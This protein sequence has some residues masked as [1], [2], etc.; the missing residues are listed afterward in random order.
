MNSTDHP[1]ISLLRPFGG[2]DGLTHTSPSSVLA[3]GIGLFFILALLFQ[4]NGN[5]IKCFDMDG[6]PM[7]ELCISGASKAA[8]LFQPY[9][10]SLVAGGLGLADNGD[11]SGRP[12]VSKQGEKLAHDEPYIICSGKHREVVLHAAEHV[13]EFFRNDSKDH[14]KPTGMN[15]GDYFNR[16]SHRTTN[17]C[18]MESVLGQCVGA[19]N[20][21]QWR[22]VRSYFDPAYTGNASLAMVPS[23]QNEVVKWL[24]MLKNDSLRTGVRRLVVHA[25]TSCKILLL[26]VIPQTFYGAAYDDDVGM[27]PHAVRIW[28]LTVCQAYEKLVRIS[29]IQGQ[30]LKYVMAGGWQQHQWFNM[31]PTPSR[32][33]LDLYHRDW[34]AFNLEMLETAQK[35]GLAIP[36]EH[37]FKGVQ[38]DDAMSMDQYL[39]TIDEMIFINIDITGSVLAFM[40][41]N[42][43]KHPDFQQKLYEEIVAQKAEEGFDLSSYLARQTTLLHYLCLESVRLRPATWFSVPECTTIDKVIG[44]Y[45]IPARTP[46]I[47]DVRRLN[48]NA[49]TWGLDGG[50]FRPERFAGR[51]PNEY[52]YGYMRFGVVSGK[53][54]GKHMADVLMKV[55]M[56]T[57]LEQYKIEEIEM[58]IGV[59]DG[60]L[61]FVKRKEPLE[62]TTGTQKR[63][64]IITG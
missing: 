57:V 25:P 50:A 31:L 23:F 12:L 58:N 41:N 17:T 4:H 22:V 8:M 53:C 36:A 28:G 27:P 32:R 26:R 55:A 60:Y 7:K 63:E 18:T 38:P 21:K 35:K 5:K 19:L 3:Y 61:A 33:Q 39:Q 45:R 1:F 15:F 37:I 14:F 62:F 34:Q 2:T 54:L 16:C 46:I 30:V 43:A 6:V 9:V 42:L 64:G 48:T 20:G 47:I 56:M 51:S 40:L 24:N 44:R 52:R 13:R 10:L 59:R 29:Q 11:N 49:L